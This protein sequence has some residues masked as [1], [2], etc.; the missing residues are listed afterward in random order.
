M[1]ISRSKPIY[2]TIALLL[3]LGTIHNLGAFAERTDSSRS[4]RIVVA[5]SEEFAKR[6]EEV[7]K[8]ADGAIVIFGNPPDTKDRPYRANNSVVYLSGL[9]SPGAMVVLLPEGDPSGKET[10]LFADGET[11]DVSSKSSDSSEVTPTRYF[12]AAIETP[13][14]AAKEKIFLSRTVS[15]LVDVLKGFNPTVS[16]EPSADRL[17]TPLRFVKTKDEISTLRRAIDI[18]GNAQRDAAKK[19]EPGVKESDVKDAIE[20]TFK[21]RG[22]QRAGFTTIVGSGKNSIDLHHPADETLIGEDQT[23]VVD[24]GAEYNYYT[25]DITRTYP[26]GGKFSPRQ[27]ELYQLVLD[28]QKASEKMV[29]PGK[30]TLR[31]QNQFAKDFLRN[32]PLRAKDRSGVEHTMDRFMTHALGHSLGMDVHDVTPQP[33]LLKPGVVFT[34]EP[35][36]YIASE[37]IGIRI[38]DD[39]LVTDKG[40]EKLSRK[41]PS[42]APEI[43]RRM[44]R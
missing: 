41:I 23:V 12:A 43:E 22:A 26:S 11:T 6:R 30:T 32:S 20:T 39:Y 34:I 28:C 36:V 13:A 27:R 37:N 4:K 8:A 21:K 31:E 15:S 24:I 5:S 3:A 35:G 42:D 16:I 7:R 18:T 33:G 40:I 38:E 44:K 25:A 2:A 19:I 14:K 9:E 10:L 29:V 1:R 17:L